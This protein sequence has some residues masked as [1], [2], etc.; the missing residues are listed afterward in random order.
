MLNRIEILL[1]PATLKF[2]CLQTNSIFS[3]F[4]Q[5]AACLGKDNLQNVTVWC[6]I[7]CVLRLHGR[8]W[9][10]KILDEYDWV[11]SHS[12]KFDR[13]QTEPSIEVKFDLESKSVTAPG[14]KAKSSALLYVR[15][16]MA[17]QKKPYNLKRA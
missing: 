5:V 11:L 17:F 14:K 4:V 1:V 16:Y 10:V 2:S 8:K 15:W 9:F 12:P 3:F 13:D 6:F 7:I